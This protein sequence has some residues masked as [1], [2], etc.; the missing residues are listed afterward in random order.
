MLAQKTKYAVKAMIA[1]AEIGVGEA[2]QIA[3]LAKQEAIPKKFL[4]QILLDLKHQGLI[5]SRRGKLGG[6]TLIK[7]PE[8][9]SIGRIVRL[10]EG[11]I[12]PLSCL[13]KMAYQRCDD[14]RD[15]TNCRV[16]RVFAES[17]EATVAILER[18]TLKDA[19]ADSG[20]EKTSTV[21]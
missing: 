6:Y 5:N 14:C 20:D 18:T 13:S 16:R 19:L 15:E 11:P 1:L 21:A 10:I 9:I 7:A 8:E 2:M 17:Y 12:A 3:D 4:E